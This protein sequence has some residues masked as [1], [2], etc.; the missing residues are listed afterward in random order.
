MKSKYTLVRVRATR[1][2]AFPAIVSAAFLMAF[3]APK[4]EAQ[5]IT[6]NGTVNNLANGGWGN[7]ANWN[8]ANIPDTS[9][10]IASLSKD[11][12]GTTTNTPSFTLGANRTINA[13]VFDDTGT[14]TDRTG[15]INTG[16]VITLAGSNPFIQTNNS[17]TLNCGLAWGSTAW[18]KNG[19]GALVLNAA[20]TGSGTGHRETRGVFVFR[21]GKRMLTVF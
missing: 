2:F 10:E 1:R 15:I 18:T 7:T 4:A 8:P 3:F 19:A 14:G 5:I 16:S 13:L 12:T 6:W 17:I 9:L 20:N 21:A 11:W